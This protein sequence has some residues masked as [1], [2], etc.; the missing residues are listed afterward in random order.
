MFEG[1]EPQ[2]RDA[3]GSGNGGGGGSAGN[4]EEKIGVSLRNGEN[5]SDERKAHVL[6]LQTNSK[7]R[8]GMV[9]EDSPRT[10]RRINSPAQSAG[11]KVHAASLTTSDAASV[12]APAAL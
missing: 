9:S 2:G 11:A 8:E 10:M 1:V 12:T 5:E 6:P 4:Y 7:L 3:G